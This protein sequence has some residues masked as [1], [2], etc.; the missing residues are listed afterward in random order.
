MSGEVN[1][2]R[3]SYPKPARRTPKHPISRLGANS[4]R[5]SRTSAAARPASQ[6]G[7][8]E[9]ALR[10]IRAAETSVESSPSQAREGPR[11]WWHSIA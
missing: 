11:P 3:N 1:R 5:H 6:A 2:Q 9:T 8:Q 7:S 4:E 10:A